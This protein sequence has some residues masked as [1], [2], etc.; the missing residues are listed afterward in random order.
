VALSPAAHGL[1]LL[2]AG[3][4][5]LSWVLTFFALKELPISLAAP[6]RASAPLLTL[7]GAIVLFAE[8]PSTTQLFGMGITLAAY[9]AFSVIGRAEGIHFSRSRPVLLLAL[10]TLVGAMSGL[11]DKQLLQTVHLP[12]APMQLWFTLYNTLLQGML[13][14]WFWRPVRRPAAPFHWRWSIPAVAALL[15]LADTLYFHALA[16]PDALVSVVATLRRSNV[17]VSFVVGGLAFREKQ[18][19]KKA[20]ALG[21]VLAG[22]FLIMK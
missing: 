1:V 4:V 2:K 19:G 9:F 3:I 14:L 11:Y 20:V 5:T 16:Q 6:I 13:V 18:R 15:L 22:L 7:L 17:V 8:R 12:A 10:G 21:G